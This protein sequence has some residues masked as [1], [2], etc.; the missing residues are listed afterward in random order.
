MKKNLDNP[1]ML[2]ICPLSEL[3]FLFS[4]YYKL[5]IEIK[6]NEHCFQIYL[7]EVLLEPT[8]R[9]M[10]LSEQIYTGFEL[11]NDVYGNR[12]SNSKRNKKYG[13]G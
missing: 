11:H 10:P 1:N 3:F 13:S 6:I 9:K 8:N 4:N 5:N 12:K 7:Q 2:F